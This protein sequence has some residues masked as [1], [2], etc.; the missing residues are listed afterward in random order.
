MLAGTCVLAQSEIQ[1]TINLNTDQ[2]TQ[3]PRA[4][5]QALEQDLAEFLNGQTWTDD[6]FEIDERIEATLFLTIKEQETKSDKG[7]GGTAVVVPNQFTGTLAIQSLRPVYGTGEQTPVVNFQDKL[8]DFSYTQ[9]EGVQYS[10]QSHASDLGAIMAF[11]SYIILGI[12]Y[13]TFAPLGGEEHLAK[14]R[15]LIL[16]LP[17]VIGNS[18]GWTAEQKFRSRNRFTLVSEILDPRMVPLRRAYYNYHRLGLDMF[19]SD[20][21]A[22]RNN[23]T[24]AIEDVQKANA[25]NPNGMFAQAFV[26]AKREEIIEIY[27]AATGVEQNTVITAMSRIDQAKASEYRGIRFSGNQRRGNPT[28][29]PVSR[30]KRGAR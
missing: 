2:T 8:I 19:H 28:R 4:Q 25:S 26:D 15:E 12:D 23:V 10:E 18:R 11:Y 5:L 27:K 3:T 17:P 30:S 1:W 13:D 29:A 21:V 16:R 20:Q 9:G 22:A 14:A 6:R 7:E 24:L